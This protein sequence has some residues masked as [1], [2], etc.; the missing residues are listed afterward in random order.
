[1]E[2]GPDCFLTSKPAAVELCGELGLADRLVGTHPLSRRS[3][4]VWRRR[5]VPLTEGFQLFVPSSVAALARSRLFSLA[6]KVRMAMEPLFPA[7]MDPRDESL[8]SFVRRRLGAEA[9]E[10]LAQPMVSAVYGADPYRLSLLATLPHLARMEREHGSL[11]AAAARGSPASGSTA[12]DGPAAGPRY[13]LFATPRDG[14]GT[15][16]RALAARLPEGSVHLEAGIQAVA[17]SVR[18]DGTPAWRV[19]VGGGDRL[20]ADAL[21]LA[22]PAPAAARLLSTVRPALGA[23]IGAI[24]TAPS[25]TVLLAYRR[26]AISHPLDGMGLVVP[27]AEG[28]DL[29]ACSFASV[30]FPGRAPEGHVLLRAFAGGALRPDLMEIDDDQLLARVQSALAVLLD[31]RGAPLHAVVTRH[32]QGL[33]QYEVGHLDRVGA[34]EREV[35]ELPGLA[36]AGNFARGLGIPDCIASGEAA[37]AAVLRYLGPRPDR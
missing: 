1:M 10:R 36:L 19:V 16:V 31:T 33:P 3:F 7:R 4:V 8:A 32:P 21:V 35:G 2:H 12:G 37:A 27:A 29:L 5:L 34:I 11:L 9:L 28:M 14:L 30:K 25:A 20:T 17:R 24:R 15:I 26:E 6:G 13:G 22:L 18:P 23:R